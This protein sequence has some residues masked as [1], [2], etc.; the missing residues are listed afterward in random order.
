MIQRIQ[1]LFLFI[2]S[3]AVGLI[4]AFPISSYYGD[5]HTF[6]LTLLGIQNLVPDSESIFQTYF[7][8][9]LITF[10]LL[11]CVL[12]IITIF[13]FKNRKRQLKIIKVNILAN[14][15]LIV[16]IFLI[17]SKLILSQ[18][19]VI[20]EYSTG[21]FLPLFSLVFLIM[22]FRGVKKDDELIRSSDRLR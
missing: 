14:I 4:F 8:L 21:A 2:A 3:L 11:L 18:V 7:T 20:E 6:K 15:L 16:G 17:Y 1:T 9:P 5:M 12:P 19:D 22:A 10:V 13:Q